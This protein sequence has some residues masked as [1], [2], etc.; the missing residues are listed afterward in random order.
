MYRSYRQDLL[1]YSRLVKTNLG[2]RFTMVIAMTATLHFHSLIYPLFAVL[3]RPL[4]SDTLDAH[5]LSRSVDYYPEE[6]GGT[7][8]Q[9]PS[10]SLR[11]SSFP[12]PDSFKANSIMAAV[13]PVPQ[14]LMIGFLGSRFFDSKIFLN[15]SAGRRV[16][17]SG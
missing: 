7:H 2:I 1:R 5:S 8:V 13:T 12:K 9:L 3:T 16:F 17:V 4:D 6:G 11:S 10:Y 14:L 15:S